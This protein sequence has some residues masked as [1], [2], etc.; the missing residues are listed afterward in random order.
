[1]SPRKATMKSP[2]PGMDPF[3]E[4]QEWTDFHHALIEM[5]SELLVPEVEPRYLVRVERRVYVEPDPDESL[6]HREPD[7]AV[8]LAQPRGTPF[9]HGVDGGTATLAPVS[10]VLPVPQELRDQLPPIPIPL[11]AGDPEIML[12]LQGLFTRRYARS[13]YERTLRYTAAVEP[14]LNADDAEWT[15]NVLRVAGKL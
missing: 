5:I 14:S 6:K 1:M 9:D 2:F 15:A 13:G 11:L 8:L 3:I 10:V 7:S 12:D 4:G